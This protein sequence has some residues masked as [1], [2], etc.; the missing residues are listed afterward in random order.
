MIRMS[1]LCLLAGRV[2]ASDPGV[3]FSITLSEDAPHPLARVNDRENIHW[4]FGP[5]RLEEGPWIP[6]AGYPVLY[7]KDSLRRALEEM[8]G[9]TVVRHGPARG[10]EALCPGECARGR[11]FNRLGEITITN[12]YHNQDEVAALLLA[13]EAEYP[14]IARRK[15]IGVT[16]QGRTVWTLKISDHVDQTEPEPVVVFDG[17]VHAREFAPTEVCLDL[18]HTLLSGYTNNATYRDWIDHLEIYVTP[19]LNPDGRY[20]CASVNAMWRKNGRDNDENGALQYPDDGVDL[21]RNAAFLWGSD[22][23]GSSPYHD[24]DT[25]RGP[26]AASEPETQSYAAFLQRVRP[27][28]YLTMHSYMGGI[29]SPYGDYTHTAQP[30]PNPFNLLGQQMAS[31]STNDDASLMEFWLGDDF[32][33]PVNGDMVDWCFA[34][35]AAQSYGVELGTSGFQPAYQVTRDQIVPGFRPGW[36]R[37]LAAAFD[38]HPRVSGV[39]E[40]AATGAPVP[41]DIYIDPA[42]MSAPNDEH[43]QTRADGFYTCALGTSGTVRLTFAPRGQP[44]LSVTQT[45]AMGASPRETNLALAYNPRIAFMAGPRQIGWTNQFRAGITVV[46]SAVSPD[47]FW[48][49]GQTQASTN[50][51]GSATLAETG[52]VTCYRIHTVSIADLDT[53]TCRVPAGHFLM[54]SP[55]GLTPTN[56]QPPHVVFVSGFLVDRYEVTKGLWEAVRSAAVTNGFSG[57]P[58]GGIQ[59]DG[60]SVTDISW[61]D[62]AKWCNARSILKGRVPVY[63]TNSHL[64][65]LYRSG[66]PGTSNIFVKWEADGYRLPTEAEWEKAARGGFTGRDFPWGDDVGGAHANYLDSG[67]PYDNDVSPAGYYNGNQ[68]PAGADEANGYGIYDCAGNVAEWCHDR[69]GPYTDGAQHDPTG[70]D[71]GPLHVIRG[72]SWNDA[73]DAL[74]CA[75]RASATPQARSGVIG[76]RCV[77]RENE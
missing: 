68:T 19:C 20:C 57:L 14:D 71:V 51:S 41:T 54:G 29:Y 22:N 62:A 43:W 70:P 1:V 33:Y 56:E 17:N 45:L 69:F 18:I 35:F 39:V 65:A 3:F 67:D 12:G 55:S 23:T 42:N 27:A 53:N 7:A 58:T 13:F 25:Y 40:D 48:L 15:A 16:H 52:T 76:F 4:Q 46:E 44:E 21:N 73:P 75:A 11:L 34:T 49:P 8:P 26:W 77:R 63:Y 5:Y 61:E 2:L 59:P 9:V 10:Y 24:D 31:V 28:F 50:G 30:N 64:T 32:P 6:G 66:T 37:L 47:D 38:S 36:H 60:F 72:G 74:R